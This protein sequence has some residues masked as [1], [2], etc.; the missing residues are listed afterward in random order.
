MVA[1]ERP[2]F[3]EEKAKFSMCPKCGQR[4]VRARS[5]GEFVQYR[6]E[7]DSC[8]VISLRFRYGRA[9][10]NGPVGVLRVKE[11]AVVG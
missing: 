6:C 9:R 2:R 10:R 8:P 1:L 5:C 4:L 3:K 7:N 11:A